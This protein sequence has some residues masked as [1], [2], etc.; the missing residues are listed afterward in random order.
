MLFE[1]LSHEDKEKISNY[2]YAY[3]LSP[4][5]NMPSKST[6]ASL[7]YVLRHWDHEK[8]DLYRLLGGNFILQKHINLDVDTQLIYNKLQ[9]MY[10]SSKILRD[11]QYCDIFRHFYVWLYDIERAHRRYIRELRAKLYL[12]H[13]DHEQLMAIQ[14]DWFSLEHL[15]SNAY[16]GPVGVLMLPDTDKPYQLKRGMRLTRIIERLRQAYGVLDGEEY[17]TEEHLS[18]L[19]DLLAIARSSANNE[20]DLCLS[21]HPL[22]YMTM[23][24]NE[25]GWSSCMAWK[26]HTGDY[27]LGTVECMNSPTVLV[28]YIRDKN[29]MN[30]T[31]R[32]ETWANKSWRQLFI[33]SGTSAVAV[34]GYPFQNDTVVNIV[35]D[36]IK[37]LAATNWNKNYSEAGY[38]TDNPGRIHFD[39]GEEL[40]YEE[41]GAHYNPR[42]EFNWGYMYDDI[43]TL[44]Q[45]RVIFDPEAVATA[46][47]YSNCYISII[48]SGISECLWCG[49]E[50]DSEKDGDENGDGCQNLVFCSDCAPWENVGYC[51]HCGCRTNDLIWVEE[52]GVYVCENCYEES[53]M[54]DEIDGHQFWDDNKAEIYLAVGTDEDGKVITMPSSIFVDRE[55]DYDEDD[56]AKIF[57]DPDHI[58]T[59]ITDVSPHEWRHM[60]KDIVFPQ[61]LTKKGLQLFTHSFDTIE[62]ILNT[63]DNATPFTDEFVATL[64]REK[65][66]GPNP[67]KYSCLVDTNGITRWRYAN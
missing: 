50:I 25:K 12:E 17:F 28:A 33:V 66:F 14:D 23:S 55:H 57:K 2:I 16:S 18:R 31:Y 26:E 5:H 51:D 37:E 27:R 56:L 61:D 4:E 42:L 19:V 1:K 58:S 63:H 60:V 41:N 32:G 34:K 67:E 52:L 38:I 15:A 20:F 35:L 40:I 64:N 30:L 11:R 8:Q 7:E 54:E 24:D 22:D 53:L 10:T 21:I 3:G 62:G 36:W 45:H 48:A 43:G 46:C 44:S 59:V 49:G 47:S 65:F 6:R 9:E 39:N 29:D 13:K